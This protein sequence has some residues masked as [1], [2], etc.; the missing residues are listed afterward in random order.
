MYALLLIKQIFV[1]NIRTN[2]QN[3]PERNT[4][5]SFEQGTTV[6]CGFHFCSTQISLPVS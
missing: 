2:S 3:Y 5:D 6:H 4:Q 1:E